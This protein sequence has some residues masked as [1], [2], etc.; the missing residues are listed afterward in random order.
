M[1]T[2]MQQGEIFILCNFIYI[3]HEYLDFS[4][5]TQIYQ[6]ENYASMC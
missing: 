2:E 5:G 4:Q 3:T 6:L 1:F